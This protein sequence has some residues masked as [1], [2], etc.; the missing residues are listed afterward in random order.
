MDEM[1]SK[2]RDEFDEVRDEMDEGFSD[3]LGKVEEW[4]A[5]H[6]RREVQ[7]LMMIGHEQM[8]TIR[9]LRNDLDGMA[10][11]LLKK[12]SERQALV[13]D[14]DEL[15]EVA[16]IPFDPDCDSLHTT[17]RHVISAAKH[18][19]DGAANRRRVMETVLTV[20]GSLAAMMLFVWVVVMVAACVR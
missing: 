4:D 17:L 20:A 3:M 16:G 10:R 8:T 19:D 12:V 14:V 15:A 18:G 5:D 1:E 9:L 13:K 6:L 7:I 2:V 11:E